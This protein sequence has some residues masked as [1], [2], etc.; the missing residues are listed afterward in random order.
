MKMNNMDLKRLYEDAFY[1]HLVRNGYDK[2]SA[3]KM[4]VE[5]VKDDKVKFPVEY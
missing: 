1:F 3:K 4:A 5:Y 2:L